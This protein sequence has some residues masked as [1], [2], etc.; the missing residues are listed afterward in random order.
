M[1]AWAVFAGTNEAAAQVLKGAYGFTGT[2]NCLV[3]LY[4]FNDKQQPNAD[5]TGQ[6]RPAAFGFSFSV[7]GIRTFNGDGTGTVN[8]T[9]VTTTGETEPL[10]RP[11]ASSENFTFNF[12]YVVNAD[13]SWTSDMVAGSYLGTFLTGP[14]S[15]PQQTVTIDQLPRISGLMA[16]N[17]M[18]LT[19]AHLTPT[20]ETHTYSNKD[21]WPMICHRSRV[22]IRLSPAS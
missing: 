20:V 13:G 3:G 1:M 8:G 6:G 12:T 19:A 16:V 17:G 15:N 7:E 4:G 11:D 5:P 9:T 21:I 22:F 18:T 2:A 14:R 10:F